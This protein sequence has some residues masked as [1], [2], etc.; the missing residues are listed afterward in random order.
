MRCVVRHCP[1]SVPSP[2]CCEISERS[3][4]S[5]RLNLIIAVFADLSIV[6]F[7]FLEIFF[8]GGF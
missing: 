6:K 4:I 5:H 7:E 8:V 1:M 3:A 2:T